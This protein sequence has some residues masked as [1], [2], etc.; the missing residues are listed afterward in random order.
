MR[1]NWKWVFAFSCLFGLLGTPLRSETVQAVLER[2]DKE[3]GQ[4]RQMTA[5]MKK[6]AFTAVLNDTTEE[7]GAMWVKRSGSNIQMRGEIT[8]PDEKSFGFRE[9]KFQIYYPKMNTVQI[10]DLGKE[11]SLVDQFLLLGFGSSG[12]ELE[13][14][15]TV[16]V[17]GEDVLSG[18]KMTR[19]E[20]VPRSKQALE[21]ITMVALWIPQDAGHPVQQKILQ[22]GGNFY[23]V[24]YSD[25]KLN[26]G[27]PDSDFN[28]KLPAEV[29]RDY[30]QR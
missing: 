14:T 18:R 3:A 7:S 17:G 2:M 27:L 29:K 8:A 30:P 1:S 4:F 26:P 21:Q 9:S 25:I 11:R 13:K 6:T 24:V 10:Y 12:K 19:L 20:L 28:L 23:L 22:P 5:K 16:K 15:Y